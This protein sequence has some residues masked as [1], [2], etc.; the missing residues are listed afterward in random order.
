MTTLIDKIA[1]VL[2]YEWKPEYGNYDE[3]VAWTT[4]VAERVNAVVLAEFV[5]EAQKRYRQGAAENSWHMP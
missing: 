4:H 5:A 3:M 2:R 1:E